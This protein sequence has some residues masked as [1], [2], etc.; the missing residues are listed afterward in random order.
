MLGAEE[1][2][3]I[4][5]EAGQYPERRA[6]CIDALRIVQRHRRWVSD[7]DLAQ[8]AALL[9]MPEAELDGVSTFYNLVYRRPVGR[10][11]ILVCNSVSCWMMGYENIVQHLGRRLGIG[12]GQTTADDRFTLLPVVCLGACDLAPAMMVDAELYGK[13]E[14][15]GIDRIL[16]SYR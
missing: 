9:G 16:Q 8:V 2:R 12:L 11:V 6:A 4:E 5:H 13:L 15:E 3:E 7:E 10:H 14:P 1:I